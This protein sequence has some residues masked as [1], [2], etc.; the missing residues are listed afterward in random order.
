MKRFCQFLFSSVIIVSLAFL[1]FKFSGI[2]RVNILKDN[3]DWSISSK[4][5]KDAVAFDKDEYENTY[6]AYK[7][8]IKLLK[9]DG[10]EEILVQNKS[11]SI[12][13]LVC[14]NDDMYFISNDELYHYNISSKFLEVILKGIPTNGENIDR[15]LIIKDSY[16]LL[17][18]GAATNSGIAESNGEMDFGKI[19]YDKSPIN[20][21]LNGENYGQEKT[22]AYMPYTNSSIRGQKI[23][24]EKFGNASVVKVDL[25]T[26]KTSLYACGIRNVTG[27]DLDSNNNLI[28]IVGGMEEKGLRPIKRDFD[29]LYKLKEENWYGWPDFSGGDPISSPR[30]NDEN[31]LTPIIS[32]PPNKIVDGPEY[33]FSKVNSI[34]CLAIYKDGKILDKDSNI[35]YDKKDNV[36]SSVNQNGVLY[37]LL[38]LKSESDIKGIKYSCGNIYILDSGIGCIYKLQSGN[39]GLKFNLPK[40]VWIFIIIFLFTL[41]ILNIIRFN[42]KKKKNI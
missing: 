26:N 35:F 20:I 1:L 6:V 33:Q 19:P 11:F 15:N 28:A 7:N 24:A 32:N 38:K 36:I 39:L 17:S 2:Y 14:N 29:Y 4:N 9:D 37:K 25:K 8:Y 5:C 27:W 31:K 10:R 23:S 18:I 3:I 12:E 42:N 40:P 41:L 16:L 21:V 13:N 30:F 22:G 34:K